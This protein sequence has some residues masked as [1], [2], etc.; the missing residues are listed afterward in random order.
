MGIDKD[1]AN[2]IM[3][4][5]ISFQIENVILKAFLSKGDAAPIEK[6]I[7]NAKTDPA[8]IRDVLESLA[9]LHAELKAADDPEQLAK[10]YAE[11]QT[12]LRPPGDVN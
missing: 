5:L 12:H 11:M 10:R 7:A 3:L 6:A 2:D 8:M 1:S 9:P 4:A